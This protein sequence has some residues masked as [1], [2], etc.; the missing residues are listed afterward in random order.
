MGLQNRPEEKNPQLWRP[1][2]KQRHAE[3]SQNKAVLR[4][5]EQVLRRLEAELK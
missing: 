3:I 1:E 2:A 4:E 5:G